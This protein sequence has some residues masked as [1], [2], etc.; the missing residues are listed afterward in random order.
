MLSGH[1]F[2]FLV[3]VLIG[4]FG[5]SC[6]AGVPSVM[7]GVGGGVWPLGVD[8]V[9]ISHL[10]QVGRTMVHTILDQLG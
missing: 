3:V 1:R 5:S 10:V 9:P 7:Y 4:A 8:F 2:L 6:A